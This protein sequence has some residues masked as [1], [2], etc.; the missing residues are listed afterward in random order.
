MLLGKLLDSLG[1]ETFAV[2]TIIKLGDLG[3]L[4]HVEQIA[5]N[6][7][8]SVGE[9]I[10]QAVRQFAA[11]ADADQWVQLMSLINK[12]EDPGSAALK[13]MLNVALPRGDRTAA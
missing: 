6:N 2:E 9:V 11:H 10:T 5:A 12:A 4:S 3:L 7:D 8:L 13:Q 1:D